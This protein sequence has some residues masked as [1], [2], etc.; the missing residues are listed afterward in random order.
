MFESLF[1]IVSAYI[2]GIGMVAGAIVAGTAVSGGLFAKLLSEWGV[3]E[4]HRIIAGIGLLLA[5][6]VHPDGLASTAAVL[7]LHRQRHPEAGEAD[8]IKTMVYEP[9]DLDEQMLVPGEPGGS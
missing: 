3:S 2:G 7:R 4:Y 1:L 8:E 5:I 6:Q 9:R